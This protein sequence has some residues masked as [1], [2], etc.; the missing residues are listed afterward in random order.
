MRFSCAVNPAAGHETRRRSSPPPRRGHTRRRRRPGRAGDRGDRGRARA[1]RDVV[2]ARGRLGGQLAIAANGAV[3]RVLCRLR[4]PPGRPALPA[5]TSRP[6]AEATADTSSAFGADAVVMATGAGAALRRS[7]AIEHADVVELRDAPDW[8]RGAA[9][10]SCSLSSETHA[11]P[12][13]GADFLAAEG[14]SGADDPPRRH[15]CRWRS[16]SQEPRR[17]RQQQLFVAGVEPHPAAAARRRGGAPRSECH[18]HVSRTKVTDATWTL[19]CPPAADLRPH[20]ASTTSSQGRVGELHICGRRLGAVAADHRHA[21]AWSSS[22][23]LALAST[24][25]SGPV[26][27]CRR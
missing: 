3:A 7:P 19:S 27:H 25:H 6:A 10:M 24:A 4:R 8:R 2:G 11:A 21:Q 9:R 16:A 12:L 13:D 15:T 17:L 22:S 5:R 14:A 18:V 26:A 1:R 23:P 20:A